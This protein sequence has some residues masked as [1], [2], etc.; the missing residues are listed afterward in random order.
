MISSTGRVFHHVVK[1]ND[2]KIF[3][4]GEFFLTFT[5]FIKYKKRQQAFPPDIEINLLPNTFPLVG[6][7]PRN[8]IL[9][10]DG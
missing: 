4:F 5:N 3:L 6:H 2:V 8:N 9:L 10:Q 1:S 7:F